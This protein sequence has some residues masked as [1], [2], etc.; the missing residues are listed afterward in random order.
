MDQSQSFGIAGNEAVQGVEHGQS[1]GAVGFDAA[2]IIVPV[3]GPD[4][5]V[6]HPQRG[7]LPM[8]AIT[9][10]TG[11][12][13][14]VDLPALGQLFSHPDQQSWRCEA[15]GWLRAAAIVLHGHH[16]LG[17]MDI[18]CQFEEAGLSRVIYRLHIGNRRSRNEVVMY[19]TGREFIRTLTRPLSALMFSNTALEPTPTAPSAVARK[20][21]RD[22]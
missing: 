22:R 19:H 13:A 2:L 16:V 18:Q 11:F 20:L 4:D 17:Q 6:G 10:G 5:V 21:W 1:V 7:K 15:L 12:V 14:G 3:A 8:Q 9:E